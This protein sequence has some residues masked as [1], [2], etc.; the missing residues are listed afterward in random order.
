MPDVVWEKVFSQS[1]PE[2]G[3]TEAEL[4]RFM[5]AIS[6]P[7]SPREVQ[8]V[9]ASQSNPFPKTDPLHAVYRPFDPRK[10]QLPSRPL[11]PTYLDFLR[12]SNGGTF[13]NG[14]RTFN[15]IFPTSTVR[16]YLVG[17]NVPQYM[18]GALPFALDGGGCFYLFD[19]RRDPVEGEYPV[20]YVGA[21]NLGYDDAVRVARSFVNT[22]K[23]KT[24]PGDRYMR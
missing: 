19:M 14:K 22:C 21:G 9:N 3:A 2:K 13:V 24:D 11:P 23:G 17:Y 15:P 16:D 18:P 10:W 8:A 6:K 12:W 1:F 20:L 7:L 5:A 4:K